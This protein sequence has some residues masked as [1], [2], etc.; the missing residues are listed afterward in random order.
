MAIGDY[1]TS[2]I[3]DT[4]KQFTQLTGYSR[5]EAVGHTPMGLGILSEEDRNALRA[6]L[7]KDGF[8]RNFIIPI[9]TKQGERRIF[10]YF[11]E[12]LHMGEEKKILT[13]AED[14]T[15]RK[16]AEKA[17]FE[18]ERKFR[19]Y[20]DNAP[21][22]VFIADANARYVE[23]NKAA[24]TTTG[25]TKDELLS[26]SVMDLTGKDSK[27][28]IEAF[29]K[30]EREDKTTVELEFIRKDGTTG[31]WI[32]DAVKLGTDRFMGFTTDI[33]ERKRAEEALQQSE[34]KF[35]NIFETTTDNIALSKT[36]DFSF[37][38]VNETFEKTS[39]YSRE[40]LI[41]KRPA[42]L[43]LWYNDEDR[44]KFLK[45][46]KEKGVVR[47]LE[48]RFRMKSGDIYTSRFSCSMIY[49]DG[50]QHM[51]SSIYDITEQRAV[52]REL[53][54]SLKEKEAL[55][56][57]QE[58]RDRELVASR[59]QLRNL[60]T[61]REE[62][63]EEERK[64]ISREIHDEMGQQLTALKMDISRLS[65]MLTDD[66]EDLLAITGSMF[67]L[68]ANAI[69]SV[70]R[71]SRAIRPVMIDTLGIAAAIENEISTFMANSP[72]QC[73][74]AIDIGDSAM[75]KTLALS[76]YRIL[77]ESLTNVARHSEATKVDINMRKLNGHIVLE[78]SDNGRGI[79]EEELFAPDAY[80]LIGMHERVN[81]LDGTLQIIKGQ[82]GKG[83]K[84]IVNLPVKDE[85]DD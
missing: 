9:T 29:R 55:L 60:I 67:S 11:A 4:N 25:Y 16:E 46:L 1:S 83:T 34:L 13:I 76:L 36:S 41:G 26:M 30:I 14:V 27:A 73:E 81:L 12:P 5:E 31:W 53:I 24:C 8:V 68:V 64:H 28:T 52:E 50:V 71:V 85:P 82:A 51:L 44:D 61:H 74:A 7:K 6:V 65:E 72:M 45:E 21:S 49:L 37:V 47:N 18:S 56:L 77:Q 32:V 80:G 62:L 66:Q 2:E 23:V 33:T 10:N 57:K 70:Q 63:L 54:S 19:D 39:G 38:D 20:I 15:E 69:K 40:E 43:G 35:R 59:E 17:I 3:I 79:T 84:L 75:D 78:V 58:I 48:L 22:G 42:D